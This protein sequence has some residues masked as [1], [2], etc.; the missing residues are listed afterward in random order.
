MQWPMGDVRP[1]E[2]LH[3]KTH[4]LIQRVPPSTPHINQ[5]HEFIFNSYILFLFYLMLLYISLKKL[6]S[7]HKAWGA[8]NIHRPLNYVTA[9]SRDTTLIISHRIISS[10]GR[11]TF[12]TSKPTQKNRWPRKILYVLE[13]AYQLQRTHHLDL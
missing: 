2:V 9:V 8:S 11:K 12:Q 1:V 10:L 13:T 5:L 4:L 7:I 6:R 3:F